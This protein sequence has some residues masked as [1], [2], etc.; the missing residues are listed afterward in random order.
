MLRSDRDLLTTPDHELDRLSQDELVRLVVICRESPNETQRSRTG[1]AWETLVTLDFD[2]IRGIVATFRFPGQGNVRVHPNDVDDVVNAAWERLVKKLL[3]SFRGTTPGEYRAAMRT[4]VRYECMDRCRAQMA[5][6]QRVAGSLDEEIADAEGKTRA[7]FE[8]QVAERE[9]ERLDEEEA[10]R[11][12]LELQERLGEAIG[13]LDG[14]RR[15]VLELTRAGRS[16]E[17]IAAELET[18]AD[19]V[20]QLRRRGLQQAR[21]ILDGHD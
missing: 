21:A 3:P 14:N 17:E 11:R 19:N 8:K 10:R 18:S 12:E 13:Q 15:R 6:E 5:H 1:K 16:T 2:R 9:R 20:Y 7:R 4:C